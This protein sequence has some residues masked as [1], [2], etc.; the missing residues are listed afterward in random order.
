MVLEYCNGGDLEKLLKK[1][2]RFTEP[3]ARLVISKIV[4]GYQ[5]LHKLNIV[6]RDLKLENI[7]LHFANYYIEDVFREP[8]KFEQIKFGTNLTNDV[9]IMIGDLGFAI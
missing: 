1:R 3:E 6:H 2:G 5:T 8:A 9:N 4:G 7:F